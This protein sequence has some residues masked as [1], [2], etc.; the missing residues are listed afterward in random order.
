MGKIVIDPITRIEGHLKIEAVI[1]NGV[2]KEAKSAG[3]LWRGIEVLL[4]GRDPRDAQRVT[5]RICGVCPTAHATAS[6][7]NLDSEDNIVSNSTE[8][9]NLGF[10]YKRGRF[11][12][13]EVGAR[14]NYR[15]FS[16][17]GVSD[18]SNSTAESNFSVS[19]LDLPITGGINITSFADRLIGL[20]VFVSAIPSFLVSQDID[21]LPLEK[22]DINNFM[23][24]GQGGI[25][26]DI[27]VFFIE[28]GYNYGFSNLINDIDS[29]S[30]TSNPGQAY[31]N[32]G[33]RF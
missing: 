19:T 7:L 1:E 26:I 17:S 5:Q 33:F 6:T 8:G 28:I 12:Y 18:E 23:L 14:Y 29:E 15:A 31:L 30:I 4:R 2:V 27:T 21:E 25:G 11:F 32:I 20:R 10:S 9:F 16:V 3:M 13:Y 24:Y 22:D